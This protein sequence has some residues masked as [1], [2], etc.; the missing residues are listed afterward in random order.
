M[1]RL[2]YLR[3]FEGIIPKVMDVPRVNEPTPGIH[4]SFI[5]LVPS[6]HGPHGTTRILLLIVHI[7]FPSS[8]RCDFSTIAHST[9]WCSCIWFDSGLF[10]D[11]SYFLSYRVFSIFPFHWLLSHCIHSHP[12]CITTSPSAITWHNFLC[13]T[14]NIKAC[15]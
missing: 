10:W 2:R 7:S 3:D 15:H 4:F 1:L 5:L 8:S 13:E 6:S 9:V 12:H 14:R 11:Y